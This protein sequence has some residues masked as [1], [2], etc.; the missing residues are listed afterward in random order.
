MP[1]SLSM[2]ALDIM[3][4]WPKMS[5]HALPYVQAMYRLDK[6]TDNYYADSA[7]SI[8]RYFLANAG[9]WRGGDAPRIKAELR[10]ML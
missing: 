8:V 1:R 3:E 2:I 4:S 9:T 7:K 6:I 10:S 5:P